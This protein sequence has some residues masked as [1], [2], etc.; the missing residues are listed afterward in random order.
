MQTP[1]PRGPSLKIVLLSY[2]YAPWI[3]GIE[4]VSQLLYDGLKARGHQVRVVTSSAA[5]AQ[6]NNAG[7]G[8]AGMVPGEQDILRQPTGT[9]LWRALCWSDAV[10]QSNVS[11]RLA[12][13]LALGLLRRPWLLVNHTP[14]GRPDGS[15][16]LSDRVKLASLR[17]ARLYTV[18]R[19]L[20]STASAPSK[21]MPNPYDVAT[22]HPPAVENAATRPLDLV[23][24]G[25]VVRAKG[26]DVLI[27]ALARLKSEPSPPTLTVVGDGPERPALEERARR[28]GVEHLVTW[29]GMLR[30][31]AVGDE[32]RRHKVIVVPSRPEPVEAFGLVA[33]EAIACGCVVVASRQGGLPEAIGPCGITV[34]SEN[35]EALAIAIRSLL[36]DHE[37]RSRMQA[38]A[39][40]HVAPFHPEAVLDQYE[41]ALRA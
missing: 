37:M 21:V 26:L 6:A 27:E 33:I 24:L 29:R 1:R 17:L 31:R 7:A 25:R 2:A 39:A 36:S 5:A 12:W 9:Q 14:V 32:L 30:G 13:P 40:A 10:I 28:L 11:L 38:E 34:P 23:F 16:S 22:F 20:A 41:A 4:T 15:T 3:G 19:Y 8:T 35:P 18:S